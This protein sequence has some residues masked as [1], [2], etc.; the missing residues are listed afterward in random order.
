MSFHLRHGDRI[1]LWGVGAFLL[2]LLLSPLFLSPSA[3]QT[4]YAEGGFFETL[5]FYGWLAGAA[6]IFIR[7][8]PI[9]YR[10]V[11]FAVLSLAMAAREADWQKKF[12]SDGVLKINY[13]QDGSIPFMERLIA[14][15]VVLI[16]VAGLIYAV[17]VG[18]RFLF[19][20]GGWAARSGIWLFVTGVSLVIGKS[21]DRIAGELNN[22]FGITLSEGWVIHLQAV[23]EGIEALA[24]LFFLWSIW[25]SGIGKSYLARRG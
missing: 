3:F 22:L 25:L 13:Y 1:L 5:S 14:G 11:S 6:L 21:T 23:E 9:G 19:F 8:R 16:L 24:P 20:E 18:F 17:Y 10:A 12:T 7:V 2:F 15:L 4:A